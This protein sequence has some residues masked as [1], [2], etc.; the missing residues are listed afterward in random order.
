MRTTGGRCTSDGL[1]NDASIGSALFQLLCKAAQLEGGASDFAGQARSTQIGFFVGERD[2][3][4]LFR[5]ERVSQTT[6]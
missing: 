6:Q 3:L 2:Q 5:F 4:V 1:I